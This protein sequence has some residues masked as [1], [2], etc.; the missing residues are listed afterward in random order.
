[1]LHDSHESDR[2]LRNFGGPPKSSS[3]T[4]GLSLNDMLLFAAWV[5]GM[6]KGQQANRLSMFS[7][8]Q[9]HIARKSE[10]TLQGTIEKSEY[11][12]GDGIS[13]S[14]GLTAIG[15]AQMV[16]LFGQP[17]SPIETDDIYEFTKIVGEYSVCVRVD[18]KV[19]ELSING[20][21]RKGTATCR[22]LEAQGISLP[23]TEK[24]PRTVLLWILQE[25]FNWRR[26]PRR[27]L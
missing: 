21:S 14:Y 8:V 18:N 25:D 26:L 12:C 24:R 5:H 27:R 13:G 4:I 2:P 11:W 19:Y 7:Y 20:Q 22:F 1:M 17:P 9:T 3:I 15:Y 10:E 23:G 6:Q 16:Q